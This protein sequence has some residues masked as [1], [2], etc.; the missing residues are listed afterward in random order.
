[1]KVTTKRRRKISLE[2][3][4][5]GDDGAARRGPGRSRTRPSLAAGPQPWAGASVAW[6][7]VAPRPAVRA[8]PARNCPARRP[9]DQDLGAPLLAPAPSPGRQAQLPRGEPPASL[10]QGNRGPVNPQAAPGRPGQQQKRRPPRRKGPEP[11]KRAP[12]SPLP[13][14]R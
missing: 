3:A 9:S 13:E 5:H 11:G 7:P 12:G 14:E 8:P 1:M 4:R 10:R 2:E 6:A